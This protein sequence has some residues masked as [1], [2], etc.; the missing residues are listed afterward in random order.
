M[1]TKL[2]NDCDGGG[3]QRLLR[4]ALELAVAEVEAAD[5]L[6]A[7]RVAGVFQFG[8]TPIAKGAA[9][10]EGGVADLARLAA[11]K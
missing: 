9:G 10:G 11:G 4:Q 8:G 2:A 5:V 3:H 6:N 7:K 1:G